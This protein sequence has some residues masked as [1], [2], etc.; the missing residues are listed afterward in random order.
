LATLQIT[1]LTKYFGGLAAVHEVGFNVNRGELVGL[2]GPNGAGKTTMFSLITG[3]LR[4]TKGKV[5]FNGKD[6]TG[7]RPYIIA[8]EG[9]VRTFQA[10]T[11]FSRYSVL[12]NIIAACHLKSKAS[13]WEAALHTP[14]SRGSEE[15]ILSRALEIVHFVGLDGCKDRSAGSLP[16][17]YKRVL[18]IAVSMAAD[19]QLLLL[20]EPLSGMNAEEVDGAVAL[21]RRIWERGTTIL[22]IEHNMRAAMNL[23]QR[24]IV[25]QMGRSPKAHQ[26][27][28]GQTK[29]S[30]KPILEPVN[31]LLRL[32]D[33]TIHYET[34]EAVKGVTLEV[35]E[36]TVVGI[37]GANGAG[38]STILRAVSGL[39]S[40]TQGEIYFKDKRI[41]GMATHEIVSLGLVHV[42]EGRGLFPHM[43][44]L[45]N[46]RLGAYLRK[47]KVAVEADLKAV[48]KLFPRLKERYNQKA[49][50]LSGGEQ[51]MLAI[52]RG[53]MA[54]P[55]LLLLDEP[56]LGLSPIIIEELTDIIKDINKNGISVLLV[57][58]NASL[59]T[60]VTDRGYVL[61]VG[62]IVLEG[63]ITELMANKLVQRAFIGG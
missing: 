42:P 58:Q 30:F 31:M 2:I 46:L 59:V 40:L 39:V 37:I 26:K 54:R 49:G 24:I 48:F 43:T 60:E 10:T 21:I 38:K 18:G 34:A 45:A 4:P 41:D 44:V 3:S 50:T 33:V 28:S 47:D 22:L 8:K 14:N 32:K 51:E 27:K 19:P 29:T 61:E 55:K 56:S 6:I 7:Q 23:C 1:G 11:L 62:K 5:A 35:D 9:V 16:H 13:F 12:E 20:D 53:L 15:A 25:L 57:E 17:G 52:C 36:G 63:N